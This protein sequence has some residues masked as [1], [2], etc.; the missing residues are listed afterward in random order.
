[1]TSSSDKLPQTGDDQKQEMIVT[2]V[3]G[4]LIALMGIGQLIRR[5]I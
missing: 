4:L 3:G 2:L 5:K 1:M